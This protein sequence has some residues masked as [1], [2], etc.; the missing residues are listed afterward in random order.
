MPGCSR[1]PWSRPAPRSASA[2]AGVATPGSG[3]PPPRPP[4]RAPGR[5]GASAPPCN[6]ARRATA[7]ARRW[8]C[9]GTDWAGPRT[10]CGTPRRSVTPMD[11][12]GPERRGGGRRA[13]AEREPV[14]SART[15]TH[16]PTG[17]SDSAS[18][19]AASNPGSPS[20]GWAAGRAPRATRTLLRDHGATDLPP[21]DRPRTTGPDRAPYRPGRPLRRD[22]PDAATGRGTGEA[23]VSGPASERDAEARPPASAE[24]GAAGAP[25]GVGCGRPARRAA[26]SRDRARHGDRVRRPRERRPPRGTGHGSGVFGTAGTPGRG[27]GKWSS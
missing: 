21:C 18:C 17:S 6:G 13:G 3:G 7:R 10:P 19:V 9:W 20:P 27:R 22:E 4:G 24:C 1:H 26:E 23:W 11:R 12:C 25:R 14:G 15:T 2:V 8:A 5:T 16:A